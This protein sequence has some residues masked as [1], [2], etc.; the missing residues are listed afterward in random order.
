MNYYEYLKEKI[1]N[2][3]FPDM[4]RLYYLGQINFAGMTGHITATQ[5]AALFELIY[6]PET[7]NTDLAEEGNEKISGKR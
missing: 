3:E 5:Q 6:R 2:M 7:P 1:E 4:D